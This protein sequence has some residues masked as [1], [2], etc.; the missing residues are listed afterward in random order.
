MVSIYTKII[1]VSIVLVCIAIGV[2]LY[3]NSYTIR[4][5]STCNKNADCP[6][7]F[8]C[9]YSKEYKKQMCIPRTGIEFNTNNLVECTPGEHSVCTKGINEPAWGCVKVTNGT[10]IIKYHGTG[11]IDSQKS[12]TKPVPGKSNGTGLTVS[13]TTK[14]G[15]IN[16]LTILE[17]G[18]NYKKNDVL[19]IVG[20][21]NNALITL[22]VMSNDKSQHPYIVLDNDK[23]RNI[24]TS[25]NG[26]GWCLLPIDQKKVSCN[27][28]TS[29]TILI[30]ETVNKE[31]PKYQ[32]GCY[33]TN[34]DQFRQDTIFDNC[35]VEQ[36]CGADIGDGELWV[37]HK[38]KI[39]C[40]STTQCPDN[41]KCCPPNQIN[42]SCSILDPNSDNYCFVKW[43]DQP[44]SDPS[45]GRCECK[46]GMKFVLN[47]TTNE[48]ECVPDSCYPHGVYDGVT[49]MCKCEPGFIRCPKDVSNP[50]AINCSK[51]LPQC[52]PD[53]C[54][55]GGDF[56]SQNSA[57]CICKKVGNITYTAIQDNSSPVGIS[58][59]NLCENNNGCGEG[60]NKRGDCIP[61][62]TTIK[63]QATYCTNCIAPF[64]NTVM[65]YDPTKLNPACLVT[66]GPF[67]DDP[68]GSTGQKQACQLL[69]DEQSCT[70]AN[71]TWT[72]P[73]SRTCSY[74]PS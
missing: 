39:S 3:V 26:K 49:E 56:T 15:K 40:S 68:S 16:S 18:T 73:I 48:M 60:D 54:N 51:D 1:L 33:C 66:R 34:P 35:T 38:D 53:P 28:W 37:P 7:N 24:P 44:M 19:Y 5:R 67:C 62:G 21:N 4:T 70:G 71:C 17:P 45:T 10:A 72:P 50:G 25:P 61:S 36:I 13:F 8:K 47:T 23:P 52:I 57:G 2:N 69:K 29:D 22:D 64:C 63:D 59:A 55:P 12:D 6:D 42:G 20:G 32:W 65:E 74:I 27:P 11:Y 43:S 30:N 41:G 14:N 46:K 58:C 31:N 9:I